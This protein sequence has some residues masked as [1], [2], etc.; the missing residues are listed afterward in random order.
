MLVD[1]LDMFCGSLEHPLMTRE[2]W[3]EYG[4]TA[5]SL[6]HLVRCIKLKNRS[7]IKKHLDECTPPSIGG[8]CFQYKISEKFLW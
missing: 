2:C 5:A 6:V 1:S 8:Q 3:S 7:K 4:Y